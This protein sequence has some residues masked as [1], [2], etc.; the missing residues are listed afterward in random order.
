[1]GYSATLCPE[2]EANLIILRARVATIQTKRSFLRHDLLEQAA[3]APE[4]R[5]ADPSRVTAN[6]AATWLAVWYDR[7]SLQVSSFKS[8]LQ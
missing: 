7:P 5:E 1:M 3:E 6:E 4:E 2:A 8:I